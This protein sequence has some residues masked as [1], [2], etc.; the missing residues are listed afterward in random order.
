MATS[1][2]HYIEVNSFV[3]YSSTEVSI[4]KK[5]TINIPT[6]N[7]VIWIIYMVFLSMLKMIEFPGQISQ[8]SGRP[9]V[10]VIDLHLQVEEPVGELD[11]QVHAEFPD[12]EIT[13]PL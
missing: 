2:I 4:I 9:V 11:A 13:V 7:I 5:I 3:L 8:G 6:I 1:Y 12:T 10:L